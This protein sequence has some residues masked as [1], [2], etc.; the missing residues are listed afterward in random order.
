MCLKA[1]MLNT[2]KVLEFFLSY[3][4]LDYGRSLEF[5]SLFFNILIFHD[6]FRASDLKFLS[7]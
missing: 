3:N 7:N 1:D 5:F 2:C 4:A 6:Y